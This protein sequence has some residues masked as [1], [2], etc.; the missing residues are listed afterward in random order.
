MRT[1]LTAADSLLLDPAFPYG[2]HLLQ[3]I[4]E[5]QLFQADGLATTD[6]VPVD[7]LAPGRIHGLSGPDLI[8]ARVRIG[9]RTWAGAV[10]VHVRSCEWTRHGHQH[11]PAYNTVILHVVH[12]HDQEI[13]TQDGSVPP[14]VELAGRIDEELVRGY[15][16]LMGNAD[17]KPCDGRIDGVD[18]A[19][20]AMW[21]ER[22]LVQRLERK[23]AVVQEVYRA[24]GGD[25]RETFYRLLLQGMGGPAN[26]EGFALL[27]A[28]LPL[29]VLL[30]YRD[31]PFRLEALLL[32]QAGFLA[33]DLIDE[34][35]RRLQEEH[36]LL[37]RLHDLRPLSSAVWK[38][39]RSRPSAFP[40]V[41]LAEAAQLLHRA[42]ELFAILSEPKDIAAMRRSLIVQASAYWDT[43]H[44]ID[45]PTAPSSKRTGR[46]FA[47]TLVIN[48]IVPCLFAMGRLRGDRASEERALDLLAALPPE[49][50]T[51]LANWARVGLVAGNAAQGQAL[52]ELER[53]YCGPRR[54][55]SCAIGN[56]L[57]GRS[58][59][60][61]RAGA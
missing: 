19:R 33:S 12:T 11:D 46:A 58:V 53:V 40:T 20:V 25:P 49:Q 2:E 57:L 21:L 28:S 29:K 45:S 18:P 7:V 24:T 48:S 38:F 47:D 41:R 44:T 61:P 55:L 39:G 15:Q 56:Q 52:L 3:F 6:G 16:R 10:E 42:D 13:R 54:C 60:G 51:V 8:D 31:D 4:W 5:R 37:A 35:P 34:H 30:K 22:L 27:A 23:V 59:K 1:T 14:T 17:R 26:A 50:N 32:G 36:R 9:P 43:H